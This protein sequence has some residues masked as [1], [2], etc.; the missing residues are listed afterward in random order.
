MFRT[1]V[2]LTSANRKRLRSLSARTGLSQ[3]RLI[4]SAIEKLSDVPEATDRLAGLRA[5][6]GM[7]KDRTDIGDAIALR[8]ELDRRIRT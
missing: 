6:R 3:S 1:Q 5:A 8:G 2:Y 7:W 4:R